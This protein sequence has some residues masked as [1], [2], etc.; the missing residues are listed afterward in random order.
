MTKRMWIA[1][2]IGLGMVGSV[3]SAQA[4]ETPAPPPPASSHPK[5]VKPTTTSHRRGPHHRRS[6]TKKPGTKPTTAGQK[7]P[8]GGAPVAK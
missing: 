2:V 3:A 6:S 4:A 8:A 1:L 7:M 5:D